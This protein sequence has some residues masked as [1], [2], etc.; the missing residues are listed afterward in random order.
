LIVCQAEKH[1]PFTTL[2]HGL[3]GSLHVVVI[4]LDLLLIAHLALAER[5]ESVKHGITFLLALKPLAVLAADITSNRIEDT[6]IPVV[7]SDL[8]K[9]L[10][11]EQVVDGMSLDFSEREPVAYERRVNTRRRNRHTL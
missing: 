2:L 6:L 4:A 9:L 3:H 11:F 1:R 10:E 8:A 5:L 7:T